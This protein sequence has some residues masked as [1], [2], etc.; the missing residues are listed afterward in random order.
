MSNLGI[1]K[2]KAKKNVDLNIIS[3][4]HISLKSNYGSK[5]FKIDNRLIFKKDNKG[6]LFIK[7]QNINDKSKDLS[8][9]WGRDQSKLN[10][11]VKSLS[12][13]YKLSLSLNGVGFKAY[14]EG[15]H[16]ILKLGYSHQLSH[17]IKEDLIISVIKPEKIVI[18]GLNKEKVHKEA[19]EIIA[20]KK[21]DPYKGKGILLDNEK[22]ILKEGKKK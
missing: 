12:Q 1:K 19:S 18:F 14:K 16:L 22:I 21:R 7:K 15:D 5:D 4:N 10:S 8:I 6:D 9:S 13:G 20:L 3:P 17:K 2:I 11:L